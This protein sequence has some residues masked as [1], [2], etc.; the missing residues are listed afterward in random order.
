M[1]RPSKRDYYMNIAKAVSQ[2]SN[3]IRKHYGAVIIKDDVIVSTGYNGSPRGFENCCDNSVCRRPNGKRNTDYENCQSVHAEQNA[4][5]QADRK[6]LIG[7]ELYLYCEEVY[8]YCNIQNNVN[9]TGFSL[10]K[11][12]PGNCKI[13]NYKVNCDKSINIIEE[14]EGV[15]CKTCQNMVFNSGITRVYTKDTIIDIEAVK[16]SVKD[17]IKDMNFVP[18]RTVKRPIMDI[19][20][21]ENSWDL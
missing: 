19:G 3:C 1:N 10:S 17:I 8:K 11:C 14:I 12:E 18:P 7:A 16:G 6:D 20:L 21:E 5:I 9:P 15:M 2:R 4:L 13:N